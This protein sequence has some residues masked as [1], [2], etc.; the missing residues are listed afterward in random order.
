MVKIEPQ[1]DHLK[2]TMLKT[3]ASIPK[4]VGSANSYFMPI[5]IENHYYSRNRVREIAQLFLETADASVVVPCDR[6][7]FLSYLTHKGISEKE[8]TRKAED[9]CMNVLKMLDNREYHKS[10][11]V[12]LRL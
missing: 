3:F 9:E 8:A 5:S 4:S 12:M 1:P 6:L 2:R 10:A 7:R 11:A